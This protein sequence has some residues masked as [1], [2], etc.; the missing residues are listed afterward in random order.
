MIY[1]HLPLNHYFKFK[2]NTFNR[3]RPWCKISSH[4]IREFGVSDKN[5]YIVW[6]KSNEEIVDMGSL[7][8]VIKNLQFL[9]N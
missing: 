1:K 2:N 3:D 7:D 4:R 6:R 5:D 8:D 9:I